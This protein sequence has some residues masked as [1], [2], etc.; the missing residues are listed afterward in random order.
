[1]VLH[2]SL[3][4]TLLTTSICVSAFGL[5]LALFLEDPFDVLSG[6]AAYAAALV[7]FVGTSGAGS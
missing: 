7:V 3:L 4:T 6:T 2:K 5:A 1:M